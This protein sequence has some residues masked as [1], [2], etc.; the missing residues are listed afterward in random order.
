[1]FNENLKNDDLSCSAD[2]SKQLHKCETFLKWIFGSVL[3]LTEKKKDRAK[4]VR[5]WG[6]LRIYNVFLAGDFV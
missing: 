5:V 4:A 2:I 1:M 3:V 6:E